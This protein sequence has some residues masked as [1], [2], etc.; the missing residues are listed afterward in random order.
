MHGIHFDRSEKVD[1][2]TASMLEQLKAPRRLDTS[3]PP[4]EKGA[5]GG[6]AGSAW[7]AGGT[8]EEKDVSGWAKSRLESMLEAAA[9][10]SQAPAMDV[11]AACKVYQSIDEMAVDD[12][13]EFGEKMAA[14]HKALAPPP[15]PLT[16]R[17][18]EVKEVG[19]SSSVASS[20]GS[21]RHLADSLV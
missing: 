20:R 7:N 14:A 13:A 18:T 16:A 19:G 21:L 9:A 17:V 10:T 6:M 12:E 11:D 15:P 3:P 2:A 1:A 8:W 4:A 5:S